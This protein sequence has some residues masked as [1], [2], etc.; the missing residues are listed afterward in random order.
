MISTLDNHFRGW[1]T[2][3]HT[4]ISS[5]AKILTSIH[6]KEAASSRLP[7]SATICEHPK[8]HCYV[9]LIQK[10]TNKVNAIE[11]NLVCITC[12]LIEC[13]GVAFITWLRHDVVLISAF[14]VCIDLSL[15]IFCVCCVYFAV[16]YVSCL[17]SGRLQEPSTICEHP[18]MY[19]YVHLRQKKT[20]N[21]NAIESI[22]V[23]IICVLMEG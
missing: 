11:L 4:A 18:E 19:C 10:A 14:G 12:V 16:L 5:L 13:Q 20:T 8:M 15:C 17:D 22:L 23:C 1:R 9:H 7:E 6:I 21:V 2:I 3:F